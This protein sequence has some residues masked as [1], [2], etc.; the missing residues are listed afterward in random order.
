MKLA[1]LVGVGPLGMSTNA[2]VKSPNAKCSDLTIAK[3]DFA[4]GTYKICSS[5]DN[6]RC[7]YAAGSTLEYLRGI[8]KPL[9]ELFSSLDAGFVS[10]EFEKMVL[11]VTAISELMECTDYH[12]LEAEMY[13]TKPPGVNMNL[14]SETIVTFRNYFYRRVRNLLKS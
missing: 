7:I 14:F 3:S 1:E 8:A 2:V 12:V 6:Q 13:Q 9:T 5:T 4:G 10:E 11:A